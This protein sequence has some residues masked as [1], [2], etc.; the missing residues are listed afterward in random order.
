MKRDSKNEKAT[1]QI[2]LIEQY[3]PVGIEAVRAAYCITPVKHPIPMREDTPARLLR[4][5]FTPD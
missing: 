3:R 1:S 2:D 4:P 5:E